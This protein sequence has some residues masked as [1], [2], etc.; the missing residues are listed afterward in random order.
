MRKIYRCNCGGL[1]RIIE[2]QKLF[3]GLFSNKVA[4]CDSCGHDSIGRDE[5]NALIE[6]IKHNTPYQLSLFEGEEDA[7]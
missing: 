3:D 4:Y 7:L 5:V 1:V 2:E 6:R